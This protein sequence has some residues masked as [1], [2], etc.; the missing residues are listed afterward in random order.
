MSICIF[1]S[2]VLSFLKLCRNIG[3]S[4]Y[5]ALLYF[6]T[7]K[8]VVLL[9]TLRGWTNGRNLYMLTC[10]HTYV[11]V[12]TFVLDTQ[13]MCIIK[14]ITFPQLMSLQQY[15]VS[16]K[17]QTLLLRSCHTFLLSK[18][19]IYTYTFTHIQSSQTYLN[20]YTLLKII[21]VGT[22]EPR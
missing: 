2:S 11:C 17:I 5:P 6:L 16:P 18:S 3:S 19:N 1:V 10:A 13:E 20:T 15:T 9:V 7:Q 21:P 14:Y 22:T 8:L 12:L 4:E